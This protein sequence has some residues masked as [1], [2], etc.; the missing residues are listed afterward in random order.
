MGRRSTRVWLSGALVAS[1]LGAMP[2]A[3]ADIYTCIAPD[4]RKLTSDRVIPECA[5]REQQIRNGDGSIRAI[6]PPSLTSEERN[7]R[8][9]AERK[10][11]AERAAHADAVRRDRNLLMRYPNE[12]AH[13]RARETA[14]DDVRNALKLSEMRETALQKERKPLLDESE[15]YKGKTLP[16]KLREQI[17]ANDAAIEAQRALVQGQNSERDRINAVYDAELSRLRRLWAGAVPGSLG[18]LNTES[19]TVS[20]TAPAAGRG[21]R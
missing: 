5:S 19:A 1:C 14:L 8:E 7:E 4:G 3:Q 6:L 17:D 21:T 20:H 15:F 11:A 10:R 2:A 13:Q 9:A 18:P 12:A 16:P